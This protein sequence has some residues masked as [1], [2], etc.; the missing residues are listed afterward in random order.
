MSFLHTP[1]MPTLDAALRDV[2]ATTVAMRR[3]AAQRLCAEEPGREDDVA[4][5]LETLAR[6]TDGLVRA[7]ALESMGTLAHARFAPVVVAAFDDSVEPVREAAVRAASHIDDPRTRSAIERA[8]FDERPEMRFQ[9]C[10]GIALVAP[11]RATSALV[12]LLNDSDARIAARAAEVLGVH[13][14]AS[15]CDALAAKLDASSSELCVNAAFALAHHR[16]ARAEPV[17]VRLVQDRAWAFAAADALGRLGAMRARGVLA[18]RGARTLTPLATKAAIGGALVRLDDPRGVE[19]LREVL[20]AFR[21]H[22]RSFAVELA[23]ELGLVGLE[24]EL[25]ALLDGPRGAS[26]DTVL[27]ALVALSPKSERIAKK[28]ALVEKQGDERGAILRHIIEES[29]P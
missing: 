11:E 26:L 9:A 20:R 22:G 17:L 28:L 19:L 5:A 8:L 7:H 15:A 10:E 23:G 14:D 27:R 2:G 24:A 29:R 4:T 13:G 25:L 16:D 6:D 12:V 21:P 1:Q 3:L 18:A